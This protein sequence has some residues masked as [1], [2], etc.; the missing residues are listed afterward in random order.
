[1]AFNLRFYINKLVKAQA[2]SATGDFASKGGA[3]LDYRPDTYETGILTASAC[4]LDIDADA[5][6]AAGT[7]SAGFTWAA[8]WLRN[9][10]SGGFGGSAT[11]TV[12]S[13]D[14]ASFTSPTS[15]GTLSFTTAGVSASQHLILVTFASQTERYWRFDFTSMGTAPDVAMVMLGTY[16]EVTRSWDLPGRPHGTSIRHGVRHFNR[17][18]TLADGAEIVQNLRSR[19]VA[20]FPLSW[21]LLDKTNYETLCTV[22]NLCRGRFIPFVLVTDDDTAMSDHFLVRWKADAFSFDEPAHELYN[23][24]CPAE[25]VANTDAGEVY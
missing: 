8:V 25:E 13:D 11:L 2:I 4:Q 21:A 16:S 12:Y 3:A 14:N 9:Y 23:W 22:H 15:R 24:S 10:P 5:T 20:Q 19:G 17:V 6:A 1:M 7:L 18:D